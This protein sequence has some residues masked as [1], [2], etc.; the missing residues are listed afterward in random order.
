MS[1][2]TYIRILP[3]INEADDGRVL[4][5]SGATGAADQGPGG[6]IGRQD[7][8]LYSGSGYGR[9]LQSS[10]SGGNGYS[11][12]VT[13]MGKFVVARGTY[14]NLATGKT[15]SKTFV[16]TFSDPKNGDATV[17]ATSTKWRTVSNVDQAASYIRS[18]TQ[19]L[20]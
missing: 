15:I 6:M 17:F 3:T 18:S 7:W 8:R 14:H 20:S 16:I 19:S 11:Y 1:D 13:D 5:R 2:I 12:E 9:R 10:L 4:G